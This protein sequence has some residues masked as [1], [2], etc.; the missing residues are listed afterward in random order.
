MEKW[1]VGRLNHRSGMN[2]FAQLDYG[3]T[4]FCMLIVK[5]TIVEPSEYKFLRINSKNENSG[6]AQSSERRRETGPLLAYT[7]PSQRRAYHRGMVFH[8][9]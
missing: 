4:A 1:E 8:N 6:M 9:R 5:S 3:T 7:G 2:F